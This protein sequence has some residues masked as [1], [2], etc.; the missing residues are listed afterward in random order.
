ME[1]DESLNATMADSRG[2]SKSIPVQTQ[3][4]DLP[5]PPN[6]PQVAAMSSSLNALN[7]S[8]APQP[9]PMEQSPQMQF[10][11]VQP[12][13]NFVPIQYVPAQMTSQNINPQNI[14]PFATNQNQL[15]SMPAPNT[16]IK[17]SPEEENADIDILNHKEAMLAQEKRIQ[18]LKIQLQNENNIYQAMLD[19]LRALEKRKAYISKKR[20]IIGQNMQHQINDEYNDDI[21]ETRNMR[22]NGTCQYLGFRRNARCWKPAEYQ[23]T[24]RRIYCSKCLGKKLLEER[25]VITAWK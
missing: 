21:D 10:P 6:S 1:N 25:Q 3:P 23:H 16:S 7:L 13:N 5:A 12:Q 8:G 22:P 2:R 17:L 9:I 19:H 11:A 18:L 20:R 24:D 4:A 14:N 15:F